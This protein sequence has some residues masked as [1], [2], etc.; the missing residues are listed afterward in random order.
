VNEASAVEQHVDVADLLADRVDGG[1][2]SHV[3]GQ[4]LDTGNVVQGFNMQV[5]GDDMR[6]GIAKGQYRS[7]A[8]ALRCSGDQHTFV[9]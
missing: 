3:Q 6:A 1:C 4:G 5:G 7:A 8:Y 2:L 9:G